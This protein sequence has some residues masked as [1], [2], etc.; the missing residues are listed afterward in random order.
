MFGTRP[1]TFMK[2]TLSSMNEKEKLLVTENFRVCQDIAIGLCRYRVNKDEVKSEA[3]L[4]MIWCAKKFDLTRGPSFTNYFHSVW[5]Y[6][7]RNFLASNREF[8]F[9][10]DENGC[11]SSEVPSKVPQVS[12]LVEA[13]GICLPTIT[14][15]MSWRDRIILRLYY[16]EGYSSPE[17]AKIFSLSPQGVRATLCRMCKTAKVKIERFVSGS[18]RYRLGHE[19]ECA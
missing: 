14:Q 11:S 4:V 2:R 3:S 12:D 18:P 19:Q 1:V 17:I 16:W 9:A 8:Q 13:L 10:F 5:K 15:S 6:R 7:M